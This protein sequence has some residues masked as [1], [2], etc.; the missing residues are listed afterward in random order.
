MGVGETF[1]SKIRAAHHQKEMV[2]EKRE[3]E[4]EAKAKRKRRKKVGGAN[5]GAGRVFFLSLQ[6]KIFDQLKKKR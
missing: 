4:R 2:I 3:R 5:E 6:W 1:R